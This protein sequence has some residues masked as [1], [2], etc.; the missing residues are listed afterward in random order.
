MLKSLACN[1]VLLGGVLA[2][3][4]GTG[5]ATAA[6]VDT[7]VADSTVTV[8]TDDGQLNEITANA[9]EVAHAAKDDI[10]DKAKDDVD[11]GEA[12]HVDK[13]DENDVAGANDAKEGAAEAGDAHQDATEATQQHG[14]SGPSG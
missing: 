5:V 2:L 1:F 4:T 8:V 9:N 14:E 13:G 6:D 12:N 3:L 7:S 10:D 11:N